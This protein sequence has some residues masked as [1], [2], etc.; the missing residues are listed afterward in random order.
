MSMYC[1]Y[2]IRIED[3][4]YETYIIDYGTVMNIVLFCV[5]TYA[6]VY[7]I[8]THRNL[9]IHTHE[10]ALVFVNFLCNIIIFA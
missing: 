9:P 5:R 3:S 7:Y 8:D 10:C 6:L 1:V 4:D 2:P